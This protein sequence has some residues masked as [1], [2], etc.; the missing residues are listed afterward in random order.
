[1]SDS[2]DFPNKSQYLKFEVQTHCK[3]LWIISDVEE[4]KKFHGICVSLVS[5]GIW[6]KGVAHR[7]DLGIYI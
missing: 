3:E 2:S 7:Y 6:D 1:M 4:Q 5:I